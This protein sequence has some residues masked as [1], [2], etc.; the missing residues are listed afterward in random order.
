MVSDI[1]ARIDGNH[2][3]VD[4]RDGL[5]LAD[6]QNYAR[7]QGTGGR[8][9]I[10]NSVV[11]IYLCDYTSGTGDQSRTLRANISP[12][13]ASEFFDVCRQNL[14]MYSI[15]NTI[16]EGKKIRAFSSRITRLM[17]ALEYLMSGTLVL[18]ANL[19]RGKISSDSK[20][21]AAQFGSVFK[22]ARFQLVNNSGN[23]Y[24]ALPEQSAPTDALANECTWVIPRMVDYS[25]SQDKVDVYHQE[26]D[27]FAPVSRLQVFHIGMRKDGTM[28]NYPWTIKITNGSA[29]VTVKPNGA[30]AFDGKSMRNV[31]EAFI[32][33]SNRDFY[34]AMYRVNRFIDKWDCLYGLPL[35]KKGE[36]LKE[37]ERMEYYNEQ[38]N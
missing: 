11:K 35:I 2:K 12:D 27:G 7:M 31:E 9:A 24:T 8:D 32:Q 13:V 26:P 33:I 10:P 1:I 36:E 23:G 18:L 34:K 22:G 37:Q 5:T 21:L 6:E 25:Y 17:S 20:D 28:S 38:R 29:H 4:F 19:V 3:I 14:G 16:G 15:P 30:T